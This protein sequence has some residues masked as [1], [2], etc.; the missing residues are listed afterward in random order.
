MAL[1]FVGPRKCLIRN[2]RK[3]TN[4]LC[5]KRRRYTT[6]KVFNNVL[7]NHGLALRDYGF[8]D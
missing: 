7:V 4:H 3:E 2:Q 5:Y 1:K 8:G 6:R